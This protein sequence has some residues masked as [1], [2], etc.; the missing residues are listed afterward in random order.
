[1]KYKHKAVK[2]ARDR[3]MGYQGIVKFLSSVYKE[4]LGEAFTAVV[5]FAKAKE[6]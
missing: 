6:I 1:M 4:K 2:Y 3:R 5:K